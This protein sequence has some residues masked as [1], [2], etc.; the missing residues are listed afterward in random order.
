MFND[1]VDQSTD[2]I[3]SASPV[4]PIGDVAASMTATQPVETPERKRGSAARMT[5]TQPV[6]TVSTVRVATQPV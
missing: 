1:V 3:T 2:V 6:E 4:Q 5:A